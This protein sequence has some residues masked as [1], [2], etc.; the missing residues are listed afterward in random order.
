MTLDVQEKWMNCGLERGD[1][2]GLEIVGQLG[3]IVDL[4]SEE[5]RYHIACKVRFESHLSK[6]G[7]MP[8]NKVHIFQI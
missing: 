2:W 7:C 6:P 4:V 1:S 8:E 5:A 3:G